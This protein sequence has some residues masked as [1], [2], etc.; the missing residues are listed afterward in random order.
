MEFHDLVAWERGAEILAKYGGK[1]RE[2]LVEGR[3][4]SRPREVEG[5][6]IKEVQLVVENFQLLGSPVSGRNGSDD[7]ASAVPRL[8]AAVIAV[9][10]AGCGQIC[11]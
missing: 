10:Q 8:P 11:R 6:R 3:I 5:H 9:A 2:L 4:S 7:A 1:G